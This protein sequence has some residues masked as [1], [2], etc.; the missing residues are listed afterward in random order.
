MSPGAPESAFGIGGAEFH[1]AQ[2]R[3]ALRSAECPVRARVAH[4]TSRTERSAQDGGA[5]QQIGR[6]AMAFNNLPAVLAAALPT[7][8]TW[9]GEGLTN[10]WPY[11]RSS[12]DD[13]AHHKGVE[14]Q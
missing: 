3:S 6:G 8:P 11:A 10:A 2:R 7:R 4:R 12:Q 5:E 14:A 13:S 1:T 9:M